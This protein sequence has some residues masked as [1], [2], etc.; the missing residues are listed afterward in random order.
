MIAFPEQV[1]EAARAAGQFR[2]APEE[3][4]DGPPPHLEEQEIS[5]ELGPNGS[6]AAHMG[7]YEDRPG[8]RDMATAVTAAFND[9]GTA[10]LEAGTGVGKSLAYL[11]PALRWAA[12]TGEKTLV[13]TNTINLQEQLV[14]KDLPFLA[15]A[16]IGKQSVRFA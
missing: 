15:E 2:F 13:S 4:A 7:G 14:A 10:L 11:V 3:H 8:Q 12:R 5:N 6:I 1:K 16:F 9:G